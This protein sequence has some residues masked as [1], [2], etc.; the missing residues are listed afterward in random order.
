MTRLELTNEIELFVTRSKKLS[1]EYK[2]RYHNFE[3]P[4]NQILVKGLILNSMSRWERL[5]RELVKLEI[6]NTTLMKINKSHYS[7]AWRYIEIFEYLKI[8]Q[9]TMPFKAL[10]RIDDF[11]GT[12]Y[13]LIVQDIVLISLY[14]LRNRFSH[15]DDFILSRIEY[16]KFLLKFEE[17]VYSFL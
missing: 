4:Y 7:L 11:F 6:E 16:E 13:S 14:K 8:D 9:G 1:V 2:L 17:L 3:D 12:K 15:G 5:I 10:C